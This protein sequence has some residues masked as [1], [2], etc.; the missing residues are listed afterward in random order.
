MKMTTEEKKQQLKAITGDLIHPQINYSAVRNACL[1]L[2]DFFC[3]MTGFD[4]EDPNNQAH[5][6]TSVGLAVS[7]YA[8]MSC[9]TDM[10]RTRNFMMG[11]QEAVQSRIKLFP[12]RPVLV[13]YAGT[14][15]FASLLIPLT[16]VFTPDQLQM[17][18][19]DIN[20]IST[21]YVKKIVEELSLQPYVT[22]IE[23]ADATQYKI[24]EQYQPDILLSETMKAGLLKEPQFTICAHLLSQ[25]TKNPILIPELIQVNLCIIRNKNKELSEKKCLTSLIRLNREL[26][27]QTPAS[28]Q[29]L[30][31]IREGMLVEF[32]EDLLD[33]QHKIVLD[34]S[35]R[36]FNAHQL[37]HN[38]SGLTI[39][40]VLDNLLQE[41]YPLGTRR[42]RY[43]ITSEPYFEITKE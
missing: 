8:A 17:V 24:P 13:F 25:C 40:A 27:D 23:T 3:N 35:I 22:A 39:P 30:Q 5:C 19:L 36:I 29:A 15:P 10:M 41:R 31:N 42:F 33:S 16:T 12:D 14:G 6:S 18:L 9:I 26:F 34:T 21:N 7:P 4:P 38:E 20:P 1:A 32:P 43:R 11:I 2:S 28:M 37:K